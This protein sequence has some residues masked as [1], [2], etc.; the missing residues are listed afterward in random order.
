MGCVKTDRQDIARGCE[1]IANSSQC[2]R[3]QYDAGGV[4][5][6]WRSITAAELP[7]GVAEEIS[8]WLLNHR[9]GNNDEMIT[10]SGMRIRIAP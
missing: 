9:P 8:A 3:I 5:S 1:Q 6:R 4:V 7:V 10:S 2:L